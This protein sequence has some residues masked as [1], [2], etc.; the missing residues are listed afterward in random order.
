VEYEVTTLYLDLEGTVLTNW[1]DALLMNVS[2]VTDFLDANPDL[3]RSDVRVFSFAIYNDADKETFV[4]TMK[5]MLERALGVTLTA[6][7]S[8]YDMAIRSQMLTGYRWVDQDTG[9]LDIT[10]YIN[11][12]GKVR[13]F[14]DWVT[15]HRDEGASRVVLVDD[16]VPMKTVLNHTLG[17]QLD[18]INVDKLGV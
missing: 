7:P 6:C 10:M 15:Y 9:A 4:R 12:V 16:I 1:S 8:L 2:R 17:L 13:A 11:V 3:D 5:P 14:E 18:Y